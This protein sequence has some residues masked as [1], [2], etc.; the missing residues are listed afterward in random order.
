MSNETGRSSYWDLL[1]EEIRLYIL[2]LREDMYRDDHR[3]TYRFVLH[4]MCRLHSVKSRV[5]LYHVKIQSRC[6][7]KIQDTR[8]KIQDT[9]KCGRVSQFH[10]REKYRKTNDIGLFHGWGGI[11]T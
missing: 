7:Y 1:P 2:K 11:R 8:C 4:D 10:L 3:D 5:G 6:R 9:G